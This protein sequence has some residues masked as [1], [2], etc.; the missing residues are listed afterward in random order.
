MKRVLSAILILVLT[1]GTV[2]SG[3]A[4]SSGAPVAAYY[5]EAVL[6]RMKVGIGVADR[7]RL[8]RVHVEHVDPNVLE[9]RR[10]RLLPSA[11]AEEREPVPLA[12][13][14]YLSLDG[15][16]KKDAACVRDEREAQLL[17]TRAER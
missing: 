12:A 2:L 17:A 10:G 1:L 9:E 11:P 5:E 16:V 13:R 4:G 15:V 3:C 14:E 7:M 6:R 8:Q